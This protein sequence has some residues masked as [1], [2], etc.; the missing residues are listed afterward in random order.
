[1]AGRDIVSIISFAFPAAMPNGRSMSVMNASTRVPDP[2]AAAM[3]RR[4]KGP[5]TSTQDAEP[6]EPTKQKAPGDSPASKPEAKARKAR[7]ARHRE[8]REHD[9]E[10]LAAEALDGR[11]A[12]RQHDHG[13]AVRLENVSDHAADGLFVIHHE[14]P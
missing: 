14:A 6:K 12:A 13:V 3:R 7:E 11:G 9:V 1:M 10:R 8:I 4:K 2:A 5:D